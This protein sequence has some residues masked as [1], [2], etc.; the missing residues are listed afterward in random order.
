[1]TLDTAPAYETVS[2]QKRL[3]MARVAME[4]QFYLMIHEWNEP[5]QPLPSQPKLILVAH[6]GMES[7]VG[8]CTLTLT[9]QKFTTL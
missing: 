2:S 3:A 6:G 1:M 5:Y 9:C 7:W 8:L 4:T